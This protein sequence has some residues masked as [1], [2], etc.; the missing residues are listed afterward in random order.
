[1]KQRTAELEVANKELQGFA[2][3][4][5]HDLKA[6]LRGI[7]R[8]TQWLTE[9]YTTAFDAK[10][11]EMADLLVG[12]V[13]CMD[14]L[15]D[16]ILEYTRVGRIVGQSEKI[17][18]NQLLPEVIDLLSPPPTIQIEIARELPVIA[19]DS[20]RI[21]QVFSNLIGNAMKFMDKPHGII[22]VDCK[23]GGGAWQFSVTDNG[24]G[25]ELRYY[26]RIFQIF[27]TLQPR[28][29]MENT[30]IGLTIVRKIVE[31]YGGKIWVESEPGK[32]SSFMFT[33][34]KT[35]GAPDKTH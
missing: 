21:L 35:G 1:M 24:P 25:I 15:I 31:L 8:L 30:G 18:L 9:D 33:F 6:P 4:V 34:P 22:R 14:A 20:I 29:E 16:G 11:K 3:V 23:D 19:G 10:G 26:E 17:D 13:K 2:Y 27:Q 12:R 32:G 7:S 5:S 28:D